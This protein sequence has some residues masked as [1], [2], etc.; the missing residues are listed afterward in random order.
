[1]PDGD[2]SDE[3]RGPTEPMLSDDDTDRLPEADRE[4]ALP[5]DEDGD[6]PVGAD[7]GPADAPVGGDEATAGAHARPAEPATPLFERDPDDVV[8]ATPADVPTD[9]GMPA[10]PTAH[11]SYGGEN[12]PTPGDSTPA[13]DPDADFDY[14]EEGAPDDQ[15]MP[16]ADHVEE[17]AMRLF[18]VVGVMAVVTVLALPSSD[19]LI[20][21]LWYSFLDGPAEA[22]GQFV[23]NAQPGGESTVAGADCPHVYSPLALILA[24][25]KVSSL[26]GLIVALPVFVYETYLFMRPGLYPTERRYYLAAVPTSLVLATIGVA[27]AYF[28]VLRAM[29]DYFITYSDRAADLAFGLGETFN[30]IILMLGFFAIVF[31][32]PLFVMLAIMMGVTTR[33]WLEDRRLYFW[34]GF[35]AIAFVFS[36]DPT[37]MAPLMVAVTMIG[38]FEGTLLL[39]RWTQESSPIPTAEEAAAQRPLAWV[40]AGLAGYVLSPA[41]VPTGYYQQLPTAVTSALDSVGLAPPLLV[42][43]SAIVAFELLAYVNKNYIVNIRVWRTLRRVRLPVWGT[44]IVVGY[45]S[46]ADPT[47]FRLVNQVS[48][49]PTAAVAVTGVLVIAF[50]AAIL[51][52]KR[53][54]AATDE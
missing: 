9:W 7:G 46:S 33:Q 41:P 25:L 17:M 48:L 27:F 21:F 18:V 10:S 3:E 28:L 35:A 5:S 15:E 37:G 29:F 13:P 44:A 19:Q 31:Q 20:N 1:M 40:V 11:T 32:I 39:L 47:L 4:G 6:R 43:G 52:G 36:P 24:R 53:R 49:T 2:D 8:A 23:A 16:L 45:L 54:G 22:C 38:L 14:G 12:V 26:V 50:E 42:G 51:A 34:G 30:L